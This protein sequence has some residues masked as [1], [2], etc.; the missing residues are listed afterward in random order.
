MQVSTEGVAERSRSVDAGNFMDA[1]PVRRDLRSTPLRVALVVEAAGGG[2]AVHI[3]DMIRGLRALGG[4]EINLVVP[5]GPR[6]DSLILAGDVLASCDT[7]HRLPMVRSVGGSDV[8]V[9]AQLFKCLHR[10]KPDIVHS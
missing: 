1:S 10:I 9:F 3:A 7:V 2:V 8:I 5:K 6:F 4:F